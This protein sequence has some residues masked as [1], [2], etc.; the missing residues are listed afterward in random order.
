MIQAVGTGAKPN[1]ARPTVYAV[2][3]VR[4]LGH[5]CPD[6]AKQDGK[7]RRLASRLPPPL[8]GTS[9]APPSDTCSMQEASATSIEVVAPLAVQG[10]RIGALTLALASPRSGWD[11]IRFLDATKWNS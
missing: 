6:L 3:L 11:A 2:L 1:L 4:R 7:A 10:I 5:T 9:L 8:M